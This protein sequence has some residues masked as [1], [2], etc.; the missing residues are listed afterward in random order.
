MKHLVLAAT[1]FCALPQLGWAQERA[2]IIARDMDVNSLDPARGWCDTCQIFNTA[3][4]EQLVTLDRNNQLVPLLAE[5]WQVNAAQTQFTF[6]LNP[7]AKFADGS[8]VQAED[9]KWSFERHKH[10]LGGSAFLTEPIRAIHTPDARTVVIDVATPN[11]EFLNQVAASYLAV[12]N[13]KLA[14]AH[15]AV[16]TEGAATSDASEEWFLNNSAGSGPFVLD[17]YEPNAQLRLKRN[18]QYWRRDVSVVPA[19]VFRQVKDAVAQA[20]MLQSGAV[21]IAM[22]VDP[23][24]AKTLRTRNVTVEHVPSYNFVY[25]ALSPVAKSNTVQMTPQVREAISLAIDRTSLI[26]F[27]LGG[28][29]RALAAPIPLGFPGGDGHAPP[30]YDPERAKALLREAGLANGF[31][32]PSIYPDMNI[33]GVSFSLMM[34]K[35]QQDLAK[36]GIDVSLSPVPF[37]TWRDAVNTDHIPMTAV[38][39]APDFFGSSQ[40]IDVFGLS[41]GSVWARRAGADND[42]SLIN[43]NTG[44]LRDKALMAPPEAAEKLWFEAG[45]LM[46]Q[47]RIIL[48]MISPDLILAYRTNVKGVRYSACC[49]LPLAEISH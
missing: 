21:D 42:P 25:L 17:S 5:R 31:K 8:P 37:A 19:V 27:T 4:Y 14:S 13:R 39:Y 34:Q 36:V 45:E 44:A 2:L 38:F 47:D 48:P 40:Y 7:E 43:E 9:V 11:S 15:G 1:L 26:E 33:Y 3:V 35:I 16:A 23:E 49:N 29:G 30:A 10:M 22:Q 32:L 28:A 20:Q 12:I 18:D 46:I 24:T 41:K 6:H